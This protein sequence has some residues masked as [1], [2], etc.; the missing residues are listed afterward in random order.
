[1]AK[2]NYVPPK[3]FD[4]ETK[5]VDYHFEKE[6][7]DN[8]YLKEAIAKKER[9]QREAENKIAHNVY[10]GYGN[11]QYIDGDLNVNTIEKKLS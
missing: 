6:L 11:N 2:I 7:Y 8:E 5:K 9:N 1:M 10:Y 4:L 3:K